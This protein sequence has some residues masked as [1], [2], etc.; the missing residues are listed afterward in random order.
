M[1]ITLR[2]LEKNLAAMDIELS[3][4]DLEDISA[5]APLG[6]TAGARYPAASMAAIGR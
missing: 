5:A 1:N 4:G 2:Y 3:A 6:G